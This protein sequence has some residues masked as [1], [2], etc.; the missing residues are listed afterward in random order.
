MYQE[1]ADLLT[2]RKKEVL[3]TES[4]ADLKTSDNE[5]CW[6]AHFRGAPCILIDTWGLQ[7]PPSVILAIRY[8]PDG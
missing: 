6:D 4:V 1:D 3:E 8:W 2:N 7:C 5:N